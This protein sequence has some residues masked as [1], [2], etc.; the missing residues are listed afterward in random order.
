MQPSFLDNH[1]RLLACGLAL[2]ISL[3][4]YGLW[5]W[6]YGPVNAADVPPQVGGFSFTPFQ[7]NDTPLK[8]RFPTNQ[9]IDGDLELIS[10]HT[11]RIRTYTARQFVELPSL[12]AS[13]G[14]EITAGLWLGLDE[15][16]N[17]QEIEQAQKASATHQ[18]ISRFIVGNET[19]LKKNLSVSQLSE[20]LDE[21]K[22]RTGLPVSTAEPWN[23]WLQNPEL[24]NHVDFITIHLLPYWEGIHID[25]AV[26]HA[27][28]QYD[29]V[30]KRFPTKQVLIGEVGWPSNGNNVGK[31]RANPENQAVFMRNFLRQA[32]ARGLDYFVMEATD[33]PWKVNEEGHAGAHWGMYDAYRQSKFK[34]S[35]QIQRDPNWQAKALVASLSGFAFALFCLLKL[36]KMRFVAKLCFA[37]CIQVVMAAVVGL[38]TVSFFSYMRA[39]DWVALAI[40][41]PTLLMM[42]AI[43]LAHIFEFAELFWRGSLRRTFAVKPL[44]PG[45]KQPFVSIHLACCNEPPDMVIA[46]IASL[47][48]LNYENY[49]VLVIDNNT[50]NDNRWQPVQAYM[51]TLP[52][53]F[54]FFRIEKLAGYKAG[55]LNFALK[56]CAAQ[57]QVVG[58]VDSDYV[59]APNWLSDLVAYFEDQNTAVVQAPQAHRNWSAQIFRRMMNWEY[60]GFFR[61]GMHHRNE[62]NAIVQHGTMTL[63][64]ASSLFEHGQWSEWCVCEDTEL[65]LR[66]MRQGLTTVYVDEP[67]GHGLTPDSFNAFKKQRHRWAQGGMQILK[68]HWRAL[69]MPKTEGNLLT[70]AQRYHFLS[71][72]LPWMGD[73]LHLVFAIAAIVWTA[74][75]L[76]L[77]RWFTL[78]TTL[79]LLP[80]GAFVIA[81]LIIGPLLYWR[82]V[83]CKPL[84]IIGASVAGMGV[85]HAIARGVIAGMIAKDARFEIT[86]KGKQKKTAKF[87]CLEETLMLLGLLGAALSIFLFLPRGDA[88]QTTNFEIW[89]AVLTVQCLPYAAALGCDL[90]ARQPEKR[91]TSQVPLEV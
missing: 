31:A 6:F 46:T 25:S 1:P 27:L 67:L 63:I 90:L 75:V 49:E 11:R 19:V 87:A 57:T 28:F 74:G 68:S 66:L 73:A 56:H 62:R 52:E 4:S 17:D 58:V 5:Q 35:G 26:G 84:E 40:F 64:K 41:V 71:G 72:W 86:T 79:F 21:V 78:P 7:R 54:R 32:N 12:A 18:N 76:L 47:R 33:Q 38:M 81:K 39:T 48:R 24:V 51:S 10:K 70:P 30:R 65:G 34:F 9:S 16:E 83:N 53:H 59:V 60:D 29:A 85:S 61:I 42:V 20:Y 44:K 80:L 69:L 55:A 22:A 37:V 8:N 13:R 2:L 15:N 77:P 36:S 89:M 82:R 23:I 88:V 50:T 43:I 91:L 45:D 14:I 3:S